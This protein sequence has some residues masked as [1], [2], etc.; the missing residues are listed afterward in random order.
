MLG[1]RPISKDLKLF[2]KLN[3]ANS[4]VHWMSI[5]LVRIWAEIAAKR[6]T[7]K[8]QIT[9]IFFFMLSELFAKILKG[10]NMVDIYLT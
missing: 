4:T 5:F 2:V 7:I 10:K 6:V 8:K 1:F 3:L 9:S